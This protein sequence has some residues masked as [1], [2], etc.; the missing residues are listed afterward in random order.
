VRRELSAFLQGGIM[1]LLMLSVYMVKAAAYLEGIVGAFVS[2]TMT[3]L[4]S[5]KFC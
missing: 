4:E 3:G 1:F 5:F 2:K